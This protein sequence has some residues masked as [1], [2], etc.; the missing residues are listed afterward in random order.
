LPTLSVHSNTRPFADK[1]YATS[2]NLPLGFHSRVD[3]E[4]S[5]R[6]GVATGHSKGQAFRNTNYKH[7]DIDIGHQ[8]FEHRRSARRNCP[9]HGVLLAQ[10]CKPPTWDESDLTYSAQMKRPPAVAQQKVNQTSK[11]QELASVETL[12]RF[13]WLTVFT[14]PMHFVLAWWFNSVP[15][16]TSPP[17]TVEWANALRTLHSVTGII[18]LTLACFIR[19]IV[20]PKG[21]ATAAGIALHML[22]CFTYLA[23][24]VAASLL[25]LHP[26]GSGGISPFIIVCISMG[27]ISLMSPVISIALFVGTFLAFWASI[28]WIDFSQAMTA[29][30]LI[31]SIAATAMSLIASRMHWNQYVKITLLSEQLSQANKVIAARIAMAAKITSLNDHDTP[32]QAP[33]IQSD[34]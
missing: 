17:E 7:G 24:G 33:G 26:A 25:G 8:I 23:F 10:S 18:V 28:Y 2:S 34:H 16:A 31:N 13:L 27:V 22:L 5:Q 1:P 9:V 11:V 14:I 15:T 19:W 29:S 12:R 30:L 32:T 20:R 3:G 4:P 6:G 21:R